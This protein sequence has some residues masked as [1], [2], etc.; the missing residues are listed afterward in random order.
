[1]TSESIGTSLWAYDLPTGKFTRLTDSLDGGSDASTRFAHHSDR[2]AWTRTGVSGKTRW[3]PMMADVVR[4]DDGSYQLANQEALVPDDPT[5]PTYGVW[6]RTGDSSADESGVIVNST[7]GN[8]GNGEVWRIDLA[9][10][11]YPWA[12]DLELQVS[13]MI[14]VPATAND[15]L[16][17][18]YAG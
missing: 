15:V 4:N 11:D 13:R 18:S 1:M 5:G 14:G 3:I 6:T 17:A 12:G 2:I 7:R 10:R 9:T 8:S 16:I